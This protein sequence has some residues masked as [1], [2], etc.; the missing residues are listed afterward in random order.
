L[1]DEQYI[2]KRFATQLLALKWGFETTS[3]VYQKINRESMALFSLDIS[4]HS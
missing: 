3:G 4:G 1:A 2:L